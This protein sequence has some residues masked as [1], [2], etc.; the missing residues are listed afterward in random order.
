[1]DEFIV[2]FGPLCEKYGTC[3][4]LN[5]FDSYIMDLN[6]QRVAQKHKNA[7]ERNKRSLRLY[8]FCAEFFRVTHE[9]LTCKIWRA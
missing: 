8:A 7:M 3:L 6:Q 5:R 4:F 9:L 1:M 2:W